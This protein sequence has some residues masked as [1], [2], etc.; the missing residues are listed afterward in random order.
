M[1]RP[2]I[3]F[4]DGV[5][6]LYIPSINTISSNPEKGLR[7]WLTTSDD[8]IV[9]SA[10][11]T[12]TLQFFELIF[13]DYEE[14]LSH[15]TSDINRLSCAF[16]ETVA[17]VKES[18]NNKK[19]LAWNLIYYYY[20][21]FY[22]A[23]SIL[24][25]LGFGLI[26]IDHRII[27]KLQSKARAIGQP[28]PPVSSGIYCVSFDIR[29]N[30]VVFYKVGRYDDSHKGLWQR[31][32]DFLSV[33]TGYFIVTGT[34]DSQCVVTR[35]PNDPYPLSVYSHIPS[36]DASDI[37]AKIDLL[38]RIINTNGDFNWLSSIRNLINYSHEFGVW[39]PY[40]FYNKKYDKIIALKN[41]CND[42]PLSPNFDISGEIE[43]IKFVKACQLI[44]A[45]N[46]DI[47]S[48]LV[49]RHPSNKSFL[50]NG[51]LAYRKKYIKNT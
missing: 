4:S 27:T 1:S 44:N 48:D 15:W 45:M 47:L 46:V 22:S 34:Y 2:D 51:F 10:T 18:E 39:Y 12:T 23:H 16:L 13:Y 38:K 14:I 24:K 21:A 11:K 50:K 25:M 3:N 5:R 49:K 6:H 40:K 17:N 7:S 32:S 29:R 35:Q 26:Q 30:T 37:V 36:T 42:N 43:L 9:V 19:F 33:L 31:F 20:S 41:L 8:Y 28:L